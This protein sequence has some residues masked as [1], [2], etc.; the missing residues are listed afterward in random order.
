MIRWARERAGLDILAL[1]H[2]FPKLAQWESGEAQPTLKQ[3]QK[4]A[5]RVH[6][7][8]GYLFLSEP[9][10]EPVPIPDFRTFASREVRRPSPD[11]LDTIYLC[12]QRQEWYREYALLEQLPKVPFIGS[13]TIHDS[14]VD[15]AG[16]IAETIGFSVQAREACHT[17]EDALRLFREQVE[18]AGVLV[19]ISSYV[20]SNTRRSLDVEEFRGFALSDD[21]APVIFVNGAD[22]K[23]GQMFTLAHE[24]AHLW[25]GASGVSNIGMRH[26]R[27]F[28]EEEVWCNRVAAELLVPMQELRQQLRPAV[29]LNDLKE[30]LRRHF[31]VSTLVILRR[32]LDAGYLQ[33]EEFEH[34]WQAEYERLRRII[35]REKQ[36]GGGGNYYNSLPVRV[37]RRFL[38]AVLA[39]AYEGRTLFRDAHQL[40]GI[41]K[42]S[43]FR[44]VTNEELGFLPFDS[45][46][47]A[48]A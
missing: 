28:P 3:L 16:R 15:V 38:H 25:L 8:L 23:A 47:E 32:L 36:R 14:Q 24:L 39:S 13:A 1:E 43:T 42:A 27:G 30:R 45:G 18:E 37:S 33:R 40:L 44:K 41:R 7:P 11:L 20:G 4:F 26:T 22:T 17:W 10:E 6:V 5:D 34:A 31:K 48:P 46:G 29:P 2:A 21:L 9:P 35:A 19:M 12:Q